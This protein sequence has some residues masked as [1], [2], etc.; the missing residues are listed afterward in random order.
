MKL[1]KEPHNKFPPRNYIKRGDQTSPAPFINKKRIFG[2][3]LGLFLL[4][5]GSFFLIIGIS[6]QSDLNSW[7]NFA[8][9]KIVSGFENI[10]GIFDNSTLPEGVDSFF[11]SSTMNLIGSSIFDLGLI[12][13]MIGTV[14]TIANLFK[15]KNTRIKII[16]IFASITLISIIGGLILNV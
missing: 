14:L 13:I 3:F 11:N 1:T 6:L 4:I 10:F 15:I 16:L 5:I 9:E 8:W 12:F 7:I 2:F